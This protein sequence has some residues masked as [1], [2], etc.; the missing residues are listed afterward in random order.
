MLVAKE[1]IK[2]NNKLLNIVFFV[3]IKYK[4]VKRN[5]TFYIT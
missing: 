3:K 2:F 1:A 4:V 5:S